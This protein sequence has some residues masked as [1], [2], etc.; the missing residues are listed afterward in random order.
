MGG[1]RDAPDRTPCGRDRACKLFAMANGTSAIASPGNVQEQVQ[2][3]LRE[4][5]NKNIHFYSLQIHVVAAYGSFH[6]IGS[7]HELGSNQTSR[8]GPPA[9]CS[10]S[11][12]PNK[13]RHPTDLLQD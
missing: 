5:A 2:G 12:P 8:S 9:T 7:G 10:R 6:T 4:G 11:L 1:I 3:D 13:L